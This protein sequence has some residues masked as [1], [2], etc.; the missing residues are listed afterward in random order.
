M[1]PTVAPTA[2]ITLFGEQ[3]TIKYTFS[4]YKEL[5][6]NPF[7]PASIKAYNEQPKDL[8]QLAASI[9]AGLFHEY[10]GRCAKYKAED[11]PT[12]DELME[13]LDPLKYVEVW[14]S[15]TRTM[16]VDEDS[17]REAVNGGDPPQA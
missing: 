5:G 9:R 4:A 12:V 8:P 3:H 6:I 15:I 16:G 11:L 13:E 14:L 2:E 1:T 7:D 10:R 17:Q